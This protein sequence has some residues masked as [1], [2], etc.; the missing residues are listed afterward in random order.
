MAL[1]FLLAL[2]VSATLVPMF[3]SAARR[4]GYLVP[5]KDHQTSSKPKTLFGGVAIALT[6]FGCAIAFETF[7]TVPVLLISSAA[8]FMVGA[9]S[10]LFTLKSSTKLVA[11][12][13]VASIFLFFDYRLYWAESQTIDSI[14]TLFWIV[15]ITSAFNL[16]DNMDGLCGGIAFIAGA[17]FLATV[18]PL[19]A[20]SPLL[21]QAQQ[22]AMLLGAIA[23]FLVYN[24]HPAS[25]VL[26]E[27]GSLL[28]G[29]SMAAMPLQFAPGRG[30]DLIAIIAVPALLLLIPIADAALVAIARVVS[31]PGEKVGWG[32]SSQRL[33]AIGLSERRAVGLMWLLAATAGGLAVVAGRSQQEFTSIMAV[34]FMIGI[35]LVTI[36]LARIRIDENIGPDELT[37]TIMPLGVESG[38]RR[39][40]VE[41]VLDLLL[42]SVAYYGAFRLQYDR[43]EWAENFR[44]FRQSFPVVVGVQMVVLLGVGAY[45]GLWRYFG[46]NDG[47]TFAKAVLVGVMVSQVAILYLYRFEGYSPAIFIV[48]AMLLLL[49]LIGSRVS[50]R[51]IREFAQRQRQTGKRLVLYGAGDAGSIA[52][53]HVLNDARN[54]YRI[55]G[56]VDDDFRM[57]NVRVHGYRVIGGYD[58]L[59]GMIMAGEVDAVAVTHG[60]A[61]AAGLPWLCAEYGVSLRRLAI[62]W[63]DLSTTAA[64]P[65]AAR[66]VRFSDAGRE[67]PRVPTTSALDAGG[68]GWPPQVRVQEPV[69]IVSGFPVAVS[70]DTSVSPVRVVHIITRLILGGAQENTLYTAIGHH[71]D[72]RFD[73]TLLCGVDEAG[74]GNMF[75]EANRAGVKTVVLPS[76]LREIRPFTDL[77]AIFDVYR[78]LKK[79][80]YTIVH[81]HSSKAGIIGRIAAKVAGVP[82]V[83]HTIHGVAFH[84][85]QSGWRNRLYIALER[86]CAPLCGRIVSVSQRLGEAALAL[87]IGRPE[88]HTTIFSGIDLDLFLNVRERVS[89]E[90]A[91]RLAG[92]PSDAPVV[93]KIARLFPLKGHEQFLAVAVEVA[94]QMPDVYF[95]LVGDGPLRDQLKAEAVRLGLGDRVVMVGRVLPQEVPQFIQAMDVVVHTSLREGIAR[96]L[97][98][99]GAVGKPVVTFDLDG[100][101]E[102]VRD[103]VSGYLVPALDT[104]QV[105]ERTVELL[106]D[107]GRRREF[108]EVGRAFATEHFSVETMVK[109]V[110]AVYLQLLSVEGSLGIGR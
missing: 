102:V 9:A 90:E 92:I 56:F 52:V 36:Y 64:A 94:R 82:A 79:G 59:V 73:V 24:V 85:F 34:M 101:P 42:V 51:V 38:Y 6:V 68:D 70:E 37:G 10:D 89:V 81:T 1:P 98:Q 17:A 40:L 96:V 14:V 11:M 7:E 30:S 33:V 109:R 80:R 26:G 66:V 31:G 105:A 49:L 32:G 5:Q 45:R 55:V 97:P 95:L 104:R 25:V 74:E 63:R 46:L 78:F 50:F 19:P 86:L 87:H 29:L 72:P 108:G 88:Q 18:F 61:E 2:L 71:H 58:H 43:L 22:L 16:L 41:V 67:R 39:R 23:G 13:G 106:R 62:D 15:G 28:I 65:S 44:Y 75:G 8:L 84:E 103:G 47:M 53:R 69:A 83:V 110:N 76:L 57:R 21:P 3:R 99:A 60:G 35:A 48:Y 100:A 91:K 27:S 93:G 54:V 4:L 12:I 77:K 20:G 107:P